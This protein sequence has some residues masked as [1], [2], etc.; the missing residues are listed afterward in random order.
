MKHHAVD[1]LEETH[2]TQLVQLVMADGLNRHLLFDEVDISL[3]SAD[4]CHTGTREAYLGCG[5][6]LEDHIRVS[7]LLAGHE[8]LNQVILL[9]LIEVMDAISVVPVDTEVLCCRFQSGETEHGLIGIGDTL[10][11]GILRHTPDSFD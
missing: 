5:T 10:R 2:M 9:V 4:G 6:E 7:F 8:D 11:V 1:I 3:G